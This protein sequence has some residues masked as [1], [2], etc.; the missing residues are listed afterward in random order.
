MSKRLTDILKEIS[1]KNPNEFQEESCIFRVAGELKE[2]YKNNEGRHS[3]ADVSTFVYNSEQGDFE[4]ILENLQSLQKYYKSK[5]EDNTFKDC[6][7]KVFKLV[8][9]IKLELNREDH[10]QERYIRDINSKLSENIRENLSKF[11]DNLITKETNI[12]NR[13]KEIDEQC[14]ELLENQRNEIKGLNNNLIS[15][16]GIFSAVILSFF[17]GLSILGS[18]LN[19]IHK[20]S[21]YRLSFSIILICLCIFNTIFMLLYIISRLVDAKIGIQCRNNECPSNCNTKLAIKCVKN[22]YPIVYW[23]NSISLMM[24]CIIY[25]MFIVDY[26]NIISY[27]ILKWNL[28][29]IFIPILG[30]VLCFLLICII[31]IINLLKNKDNKKNQNNA[32]NNKGLGM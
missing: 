20:V 11:K 10:I 16:L 26:Y 28:N 3:Y 24:I 13:Y 15:V 21:R 32:L 7:I 1:S 6:A 31:I 25:I 9:H 4:Y 17:G 30:L 29:K 5:D 12:N 23:F 22:K 8:D 14:E 18:V 19:N 27:F 2:Y